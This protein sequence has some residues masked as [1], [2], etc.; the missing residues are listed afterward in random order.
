MEEIG[1]G[2]CLVEALR[3]RLGGSDRREDLGGDFVLLRLG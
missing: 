1:Q 2:Y 3:N